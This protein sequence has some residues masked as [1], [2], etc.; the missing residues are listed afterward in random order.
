MLA[1]CLGGCSWFQKKIEEPIKDAATMYQEAHEQM[2]SGTYDT[3]IKSYEKLQARYPYGVYAQQAQLDVAYSYYMT[4]DQASAITACE[5]FIKTYPNHPKVDY[6]YY[7]KGQALLGEGGGDAFSSLITP[8]QPLEQRD[9]KGLEEAY[10]VFRQIITKFPNSIYT[11]DS[12]RQMKALTD[13]L[14][15]HELLAARYY[16]NRRSPLAAVNRAQYVIKTFPESTSVEEALSIMISGYDTLGIPELRDD[17][18]R[19]L[20]Q[21]YPNSTY[22]AKR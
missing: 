6:A 10:D 22:L 17:T 5:R 19:I 15:A 7:L 13:A 1:L 2:V 8:L 9:P 18:R 12:K 11:P 3:A 21:N 20:S 14:A 4:R 16:L